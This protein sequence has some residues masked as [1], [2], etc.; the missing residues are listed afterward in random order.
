MLKKILIGLVALVVLLV[1]AALAIIAFVDVDRFKPQIEQAVADRYQR[2]LDIGGK[3]SLSVFP[4]IALTLPATTLSDPAGTPNGGQTA[5]LGG[6][7]V[8]VALL[9]LLRGQV[10]ADRVTIDGL[11]ARVVRRADGSLSI[12]DL[13]GRAGA[14]PAGPADPADPA[15]GKTASPGG[16]DGSAGAPGEKSAGAGQLPELD[17][18]GLTLS[19]ARIEFD[20]QQAGNKAVI[21]QLD[22]EAGRI[23]TAGRTPLSLSMKLSTTQP[24]AAADVSFKGEADYDLN[25]GRYGARSLAATIKG[26]YD[27]TTLDEAKLALA[28]VTAEPARGTI[29]LDGLDLVASGKLAAGGFE[30]KVAA[31]RLK[32]DNEAA[33][34]ETVTATVRLAGEQAVDARIEA[35]T[36]SGKASALSIA[37]LAVDAT[38]TT[39]PRKLVARLSTPVSG[40]TAAGTWQLGGLAGQVVVTDPQIPNGTATLDLKGTASADTKKETA[41]V[42]LAANG[43]GTA[44][45]A[46]AGVSGF[47][48]PKI[49]FDVKADRL[50]V[51]RFLPPAAAGQ[52]PAG[53]A[54]ATG[55]APAAAADAPIDL[56]ALR[57]LTVDGRLAI[58]QLR[59][60]GLEASQLSAAIKAAGGKV[61]VAP[62]SA[63]L[64]Q[65]KLAASA[66]VQAGATPPANRFG[67]DVDLTQIAIGPLLHAVAD[68][69]MLEG[70]GNVRLS[71]RTGGATVPALKQAL[72]G[73]GAINLTN[74]AIKGINLAETIRSARSLIQ[75]GGSAE[76]RASDQ[77]KKTDFTALDATFVLSNGVATSTDLDVK[78]P[79]IRIGGDGTADLVKEQLNYTVRASVVATS[80]GQGGKDL[81]D[82]N[83]LTVPVR[84]TGP[85]AAPNW[86]IDWVSA[87]RDML[88]SRAANELKERLKVDELEDKAKEKARERVGDAL[89][90]LL[91]R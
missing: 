85:L 76:N 39:G 47:T 73:K 82:L 77:S 87:G 13:L 83:G 74:G 38:A 20:D 79:L 46:Q 4:R 19:R 49:Q 16:T 21:E 12:D 44:L 78:S 2:T 5:T 81:A 43:E 84:L 53:P 66:S 33:S 31:P 18:G 63:N 50:D 34:G 26:R 51:D 69:D 35:S 57:T 70:R 68:N 89:K 40:D 67:L 59:A 42:E 65:G 60:R 45:T 62:I 22:L 17:I 90:G 75:G 7:H 28:R 27:T 88:K 37:R 1:V 11:N 14:V 71:A 86:Q 24:Q 55:S 58:G 25:A 72:D 6:A 54:P 32:I 30:A 29:D 41:R 48:T 3:L 56:S 36:I 10:V 15:D 91:G 64:Y 9:P 61:D 52:K 23:T 80:G 8:S